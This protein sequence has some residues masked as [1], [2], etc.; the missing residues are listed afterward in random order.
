M[1]FEKLVLRSLS[2]IILIVFSLLSDKVRRGT[3]IDKKVDF[4]IDDIDLFLK[5]G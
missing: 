4:L 2:I 5:N 1:T 3:D